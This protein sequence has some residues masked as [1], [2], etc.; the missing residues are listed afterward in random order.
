[1]PS[2]TSK[3]TR[4]DPHEFLGKVL[5]YARYARLS[6]LLLICGLLA[7]VIYY[8]YS[9][10]L[11]FSRGLVK[12]RV[13]SFAV[14]SE[15]GGQT[16][17]PVSRAKRALATQLR[18]NHLIKQT[19]IRMGLADNSVSAGSIREKLLP[20]VQLSFEDNDHLQLE[21]YSTRPEVV[22]DF[23]AALVATF[24]ESQTLTRKEYREQAVEKY[25]DELQA[26]K[27]KLSLQ[28]EA[29]SKFER[30]NAMVDVFVAQKQ[31]SQI[32]VEIVWVRH[33]LTQ[34]EELKSTLAAL[35]GDRLSHLSLLS[36]FG[37][38]LPD[39]VG[40]VIRPE[41]Q[42]ASP[43]AVKETTE[44]VLKAP[45][46]ANR[47]AWEKLEKDRRLAEAELDE[48][49]TVY[50][51]GHES[52]RG[53]STKLAGL[54]QK[55][56]LELELATG[57]FER[58]YEKLQSREKA[59]QKQL[60]EYHQI[61]EKYEQ[62]RLDFELLS[63]G[64][65]AWDKAHE[66]ISHRIAALEFGADKDRVELRLLDPTSLRDKVP[67][68]PN[69]LKLALISLIV[70]IGLATGVPI[71]LDMFNNTASRLQQ[72]ESI[73]GLS[74]LGVVP[75]CRRKDLEDVSRSPIL[76]ATVP[77]QLLESFRIIRSNICLHPN[78]ADRSQVVMI[79]SA[80][81]SEGKT[82]QAANIAWAFHSI[83]ERTLLVD[84]DLR[85]GRVHE[86][87]QL[88]N[89][90]GTSSLLTGMASEEEVIQKTE[91]DGLDVITRGPIIA[92]STEILSRSTFDDLV[93]GWRERY[94]RVVIDTPP[95]LGLSETGAVQRVA[96]GVAVVIR[97]ESTTEQD[98]VA[99]V[100][101]LRR[102]DAHIYG[103]VL[104]RINLDKIANY[105]HYRYYSADYYSSFDDLPPGE[106][107]VVEG[108]PLAPPSSRKRPLA[109]A[110]KD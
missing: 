44:S 87:M 89:T 74:A 103:F 80:C 84:T 52:V 36:S 66:E 79:T 96:D 90:H 51:P 108:T 2:P 22:R 75:L 61:T 97:A 5:S 71:L 106:S 102:T 78:H 18:S 93:A 50:G 42:G 21:V 58:E 86:L 7:G 29:K 47:N 77:N 100:D 104:N 64:E 68:T 81:P 37:Q 110:D 39:A 26:I 25:I 6:F 49:R 41:R 10:A 72:I 27:T 109:T 98:I 32:P 13:Y 4:F 70:G 101:L 46:I 105:Y 19:A 55:I 28:M 17:Q 14:D 59:L 53:L 85:R 92:G 56:D 63:K 62:F 38:D 15:A 57:Q 16:N 91:L 73:T 82:T 23:P 65:L 76:G 107:P 83:G 11:Y 99:A 9:D 31:L 54:N 94:D 34:M 43:I 35:D 88:D 95:V 8:V 67:V 48:A 40:R 45:K 20:K 1:M 33:R 3:G 30:E 60:P 12:V 24:Q 69:K